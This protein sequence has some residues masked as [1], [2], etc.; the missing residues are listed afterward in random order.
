MYYTLVFERYGLLLLFAHDTRLSP[1]KYY[2]VQLSKIFSTLIK[3][4]LRLN[5]Q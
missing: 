3:K 5:V 1:M 2:I 4:I